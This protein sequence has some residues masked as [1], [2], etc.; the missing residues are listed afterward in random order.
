[1]KKTGV[2][3]E[4]KFGGDVFGRTVPARYVY[5][6]E[7][8]SAEPVFPYFVLDGGAFHFARDTFGTADSDAW[9]PRI[10]DGSLQNVFR[11]GEEPVLLMPSYS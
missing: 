11:Q 1:M 4:K 3:F 10:L 2:L 9:L 5:P 8:L 7:L 6:R